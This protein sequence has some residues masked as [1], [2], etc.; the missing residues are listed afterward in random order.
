VN[1]P[2]L[3]LLCREE[4]QRNF[5]EI[6]I[7]YKVVSIEINKI[8][9]KYSSL[10]ISNTKILYHFRFPYKAV[11]LRR[12]LTYHTSMLSTFLDNRVGHT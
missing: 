11:E 2:I 4:R 8:K 1:D 12:K 3:P 9:E 5:T 7:G 6:V 10:G